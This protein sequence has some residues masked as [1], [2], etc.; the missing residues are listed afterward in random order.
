MVY[1]FFFCK[2][3]TAYE[4][5]IG[6]WSSDVCAS[7]L[8]RAVDEARDPAALAVAE[9]RRTA[10]LEIHRR[11]LGDIVDRAGEAVAAI[12]G[13]LRPA[14]D[15]DALYALHE[16]GG[17]AETVDIDAVDEGRDDCFLTGAA[18]LRHAANDRTRGSDA[19]GRREV[20]TGGVP[21]TGDLTV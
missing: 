5:R 12:L 18:R 11:L 8:Q 19:A 10:G 4:M 9:H 13:A 6:D 2:Q 17:T 14:Q 20:R 15:L 21:P 16:D 3:K 7:D 1:V